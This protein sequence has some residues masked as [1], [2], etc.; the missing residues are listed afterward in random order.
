MKKLSILAIIIILCGLSSCVFYIN[1]DIYVHVDYD[2][3]QSD[4]TVYIDYTIYNSGNIPLENV[5]VEFG[6]DTENNNN[7]NGI[8]DIQ[9]W[10]NPVNLDENER[11]VVY[12]FRIPL[13]GETAYSV[14][15]LS[16][17]MDNPPDD[18][19]W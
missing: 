6:I 1:Y 16:V 12:D 7:F 11:H 5:A 19:D 4:N 13:Y 2:W 17:A 10:T 14:G 9:A 18:E 8:L 15:L 3:V